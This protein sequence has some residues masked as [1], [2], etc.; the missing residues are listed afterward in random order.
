MKRG[1]VFF[2]SSAALVGLVLSTA[3]CDTDAFC[4]GCSE[5]SSSGGNQGGAGGMSGAGGDAGS[6]G[7]VL[8]GSGGAGGSCAADILTDPKNCGACGDVCAVPNAFPKC[9]GGF[10]LVDTCASGFIDLD[11]QVANGCEYKCTVSNNG[12]EI[13]DGL[14]NDCNGQVDELTNLQNDPVNCGACNVVCAYANASASCA[15]GVC[16]L[17]ECFVGYYDVNADATD[18]CEYACTVTN[19][20]VEVCD[21]ADNDC[22]QTID[23]GF[24]V[25]ADPKNCGTCGNDCS[26]LY[27]N[28]APT[29]AAGVCMFGACL[30]GHYNLDG[31]EANGCEYA[32]TPA[33]AE[34]CNGADD[35]CNGLVDDGTL[36]GVGDAC[37]MSNVGECAL[38]AQACQAGS[39]VCVGEIGPSVELCDNLD[40]DCSGAADEP[41]PSANTSDK[42]LDTGVN[43]AVGQ[44]TSTQLSVAARGDVLLATYLDRRT[45]DA[46]IRANVSTDGGTTWLANDVQVAG[47]TLVQVEPWAFLSPTRAYVA[48][49]Q[50]PN[51]THRDVYIA[52][53]AAP[54][55]TFGASVRVDK[56]ATSADAF[57]VRG[58]VAK[59]GAS[60]TLV[61]VW[62]S[63]SGTGANVTTN[64]YLQRST[65]NGTTW[66]AADRRVNAVVGKA[67]LPVV[68]T[69]GN[70]KVFVAWRDSRNGKS[71]VY[72][73][74]Y[75]ATAD[76]L[77]GNV[78]VSGGNPAEQI[79]IAAD[80]GGPNVYIAWTDL[81]AA[82][83]SIR[84]NRST[85]SGAAFQ[86]D[87]AVVNV[88]ST[89][90]D[91]SAPSLASA[92]G[93]VVVAWEDTRSG[94]A[95]IRLNRSTDAGATFLPT[96]PRADLGT[97]AGTS[98]STKPRVT[99][100]AAGLVFVTW[101]DARN[102]QRDIYA[103][104]SFDGGATFQPLDLRMDVGMAGAPSPAGAADSRSPFVMTN[105]SGARAI[106]TWIDNR[107]S[108][109]TNGANADIYT[110][111]FE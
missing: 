7:I 76:T 40:N 108:T 14:D 93:T 62:Q 53:A 23:E 99:L 107:T 1:I 46:D 91:A 71:E 6:G 32:C 37:G 33:F 5:A 54:Y 98:A 84:M 52:S 55:S 68:A 63:L 19:G 90:A 65:N 38:G 47:T 77:A 35:D 12:D 80:A 109:G 59:P 50:F 72:A 13:C 83:K 15:A 49:A 42:R 44:A 43:S 31:I 29:C 85:N 100:G 79:T 11:N 97:T 106:V 17:S 27:P 22:D 69:D 102:G 20:G 57:L 73:D 78:A 67:E 10:C 9:E 103:N 88:D 111:Y 95:D 48:F 25:Q 110:N 82:K 89:F 26:T 86:A 60:D 96:S 56:D 16:A 36:P 64:V 51:T 2:A 8:V 70:G 58:V 66:L 92:S 3:G 24:D 105:A 30:P 18:G 104:H 41:C 28:A 45:G 21:Y 101:E 87:G 4:F 74:V 75:D 81:R 34:T 39:L 94:V 61:V